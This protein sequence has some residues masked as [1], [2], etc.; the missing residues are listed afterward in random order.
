MSAFLTLA[1]TNGGDVGTAPR[2]FAAS[3]NDTEAVI[4]AAG[5]VADKVA[6]KILKDDDL[7][8]INYDVDGTQGQNTYK[9]SGDDLIVNPDVSAAQNGLTA[10]AGGGQSGATALKYGVNRVT[11]VA[12]AG[13]SVLLPAAKA[14]HSVAVINADAAEAMDMFPAVG[15]SINALSAN[16]ALSVAVN[17]TLLLVC[18]VDGIWNSILTA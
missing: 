12:T 18:A 9:V 14:G 17:K 5:Y 8:T 15:E 4:L 16:T 11:V 13:D 1:Q 7:L 10:L 3:T 6:E 2:Q